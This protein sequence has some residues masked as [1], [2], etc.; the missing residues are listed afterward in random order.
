MVG[1]PCKRHNGQVG[2][3]AGF[4]GTHLAVE[5]QG[6]GGIERCEPQCVL[7]E[8]GVGPPLTC[9]GGHDRG[10]SLVEHVE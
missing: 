6:P 9:A 7:R 8:Q 2:A 4:K 3:L 10:A 5:S 1:A